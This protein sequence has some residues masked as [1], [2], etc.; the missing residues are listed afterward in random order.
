MISER[1]IW[2]HGSRFVVR[3]MALDRVQIPCA[4]HSLGWRQPE[5]GADPR[6]HKWVKARRTVV[7]F[8][9]GRYAFANVKNIKRWIEYF[10]RKELLK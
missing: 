5:T 6:T 4:Q 8:C 10:A 7:V 9:N 1:V 3:T 2:C